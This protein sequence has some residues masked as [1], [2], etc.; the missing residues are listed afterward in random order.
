MSASDTNQKRK[1]WLTKDKRPIVI[2][3]PC[4]AETEEQVMETGKRIAQTGKVDIFRAGIWKPRTRPGTFEGVGVKGLPW[5]QKVKESTGMP[6][7]VEV[8][9]ASHVELCL[10]FGIDI[11][12]I[13]AR[14]SVNPFVVQEIADAVR[15]VDIPILV[16]NPINPDLALWMGAMERFMAVGIKELGAIHRGF[17]NLGE[18]YYRNRPHWQIAL[19]FKRQMPDIPLINDPS[20]ICGRRDILQD[21]GQKAMD[22]DFDGLM[23]ESHIDPDN[24][25]SDAKQQITPEVLGQMITDMILREDYENEPELQSPIE[26]FRQEINLIDDELINLL[27]NRMTVARQ[28]GAYKKKNNMTIL[29]QKRWNDIIEKSKKQ[30]AKSGLSEQFIMSFIK[31]IHNESIDQ[32][33]KVYKS[34]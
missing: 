25:W 12:W 11:L 23:I 15:G 9:K 8:A 22:L 34:E 20:H 4:S 5:L 13:G 16:K 27:S 7:T 6:L 19:D 10:E 29:Q 21:V 1:T 17:S 28:I 31:A 30:A 3:G 32:Q 2:A 26:S 33:E 18:T 14:T 24:A